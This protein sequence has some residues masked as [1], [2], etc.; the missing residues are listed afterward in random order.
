[1]VLAL[2]GSGMVTDRYIR[3]GGGRLVHSAVHGWYIHDA[4]GSVVMRVNSAG[5]VLHMY[6]YTAF[7][8]Y[9]ETTK[10][11]DGGLTGSI[12]TNPFRFQGMY[13]DFHRGEFMTPNRMMNPRL[14]RWSQPDPYWGIHNMQNCVWSITQAGNL[15]MFVMHNPVRFRDPTGLYVVDFIDYLRAMGATVTHIDP[16]DGRERV[17]VTYGGRTQNWF[18]NSGRMDNRNINA[19]FGWSDFLTAADRSAGVGIVI[20]GGNL[21][22]NVTTPVNAA[23]S[24]TA[25]YAASLRWWTNLGWFYNQMNHNAPWDIKVPARWE[26]TIGSTFLGRFDTPIYFRGSRMTPESL[27]NWTYGYIGAAMGI[28]LT[29]LLGGSFYAAGFPMPSNFGPALPPPFVGPSV[30]VPNPQFQDEMGDWGYI[31]RGFHARRR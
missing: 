2:D 29:I 26:E 1:M 8:M 6:R 20:T 22:R 19:H 9:I 13:Y 5:Q 11:G 14:G 4:R 18:L 28:P 17:S 15:Y 3:G 23:L 27:G 16:R 31:R 24:V 12:S 21:Y 7:G 30:A 10:N 25:S